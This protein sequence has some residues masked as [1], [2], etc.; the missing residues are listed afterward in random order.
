MI[1]GPLQ[2]QRVSLT[3]HWLPVF[4]NYLSQ[5]YMLFFYITESQ[6]LYC[7]QSYYTGSVLKYM[8]T[9][10]PKIGAKDVSARG[11]IPIMTPV[12]SMDAPLRFA[13]ICII[14]RYACEISMQ[15][16]ELILNSNA[17]I[18]LS[19]IIKIHW[20]PQRTIYFDLYQEVQ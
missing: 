16:H 10:Q 9:R 19:N 14:D 7:N 17:S 5:I 4:Y 15:R 8:L 6:K 11:V 12:A 2:K 20:P 18:G 3:H 1:S 13:C